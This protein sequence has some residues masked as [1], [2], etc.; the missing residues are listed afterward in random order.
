M[1]PPS[2]PCTPTISKP[3]VLQLKP[4][5]IQTTPT[6]LFPAW[7]LL[8]SRINSPFSKKLN[9][10]EK[11]AQ[12][13]HMTINRTKKII[14]FNLRG[15]STCPR[16]QDDTYE[17]VSSRK[18]VGTNCQFHTLGKISSEASKE[19]YTL[20]KT[21]NSI[22]SIHRTLTKFLMPSFFHAFVVVFQ[23]MA[24]IGVP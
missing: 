4:S 10:F 13:K 2:F 14:R 6:S 3:E 16:K 8:L 20:S 5:N 17:S 24:A 11:E 19:C 18:I 12:D 1:A 7:Q 23:F 21:L 15:N 22:I 9:H